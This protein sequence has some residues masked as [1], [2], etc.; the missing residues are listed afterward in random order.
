[1]KP[2]DELTEIETEQEITVIDEHHNSYTGQFRWDSEEEVHKLD[3][4]KIVAHYEDDK[5]YIVKPIDDD[6]IEGFLSEIRKI[7]TE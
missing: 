7:R 6:K 4:Y 2:I 3:E 1:M 5:V